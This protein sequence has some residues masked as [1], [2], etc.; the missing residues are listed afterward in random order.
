[1]V[2]EVMIVLVVSWWRWPSHEY[3]DKESRVTAIRRIIGGDLVDLG[4]ERGGNTY[5]WSAR[6]DDV[7]KTML[8][9]SLR[10]LAEKNR[11]IS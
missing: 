2:A 11:F 1:M 8:A 3:G 9:S 4:I 5:A 7:Q 10:Q 6:G